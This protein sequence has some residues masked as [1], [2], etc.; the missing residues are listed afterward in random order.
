MQDAVAAARDEDFSAQLKSLQTAYA[1]RIALR[2]FLTEELQQLVML[3]H[4]ILASVVA[5]TYPPPEKPGQNQKP[6]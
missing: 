1:G 5:R 6:F 3:L 4:P 2:G